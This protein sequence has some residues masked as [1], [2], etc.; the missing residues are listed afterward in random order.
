M[1][2]LGVSFLFLF[3]ISSIALADTVSDISGLIP[4]NNQRP[5]ASDLVYQGKLLLPDEAR[6]L[7]S[8]GIIPDLS[9]INPDES[10]IL[11]KDSYPKDIL[12]PDK[13]ISIDLSRPFEFLEY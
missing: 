13:A 6:Q 10:S 3:L 11:W 7:Q 9:L 1:K 8:S 2:K 5:A 12:T 4:L